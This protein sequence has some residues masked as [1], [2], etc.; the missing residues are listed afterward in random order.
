MVGR[1][2]E[3]IVTSSAATKTQAQRDVMIVAVCTR[4][5]A[6]C[7]GRVVSGELVERRVG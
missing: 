4:E 2:V 7:G 1:A 6:A 5:R 3:M